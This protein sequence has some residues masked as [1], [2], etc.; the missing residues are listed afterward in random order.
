MPNVSNIFKSIQDIMR[1]DAGTYGDAQRPHS[2]LVI[3]HLIQRIR[4]KF[5]AILEV[6]RRTYRRQKSGADAVAFDASLS[7]QEPF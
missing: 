4:S 2:Y 7:H 1:K 6:L 3:G 5:A